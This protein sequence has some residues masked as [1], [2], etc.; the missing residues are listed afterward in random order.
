[1]M[2]VRIHPCTNATVTPSRNVMSS[3]MNLPTFPPMESWMSTVLPDIQPMTSPV[4]LCWSKKPTWSKGSIASSS[5]HGVRP[6]LH[7]LEE[8]R[9]AA[10]LYLGVL[11]NWRKGAAPMV[12]G[13]VSSPTGMP[14]G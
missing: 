11:E 8:L 3:W 13:A 2:S 1:M 6:V 5:A 9:A 7:S 12:K 14:K 10:W 4:L